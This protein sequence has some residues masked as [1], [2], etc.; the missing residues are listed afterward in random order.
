M[1]HV[2]VMNSNSGKAT[3]LINNDI[4][5]FCFFPRICGADEGAIMGP[6][7]AWGCEMSRALFCINS[8]S[9]M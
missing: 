8:A 7:R 9:F 3:I 1:T 4:F 5:L 2:S 6:P